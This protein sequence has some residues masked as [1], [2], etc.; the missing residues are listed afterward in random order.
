MKK[1]KDKKLLDKY[2]KENLL[3]KYLNSELINNCE[4]HIFNKNEMI[5]VLNEDMNYMYFLVK[6]KA[7]VYTFLSTGK[8]LLLCFIT[9]LSIMGDIEFL[10]NPAADCSVKALESCHCIA[11][12]ITKVK[13]FAYDDATFLRFI[14]SSLEKKLRNNANSS[15]INM[16]YPLENR[17]ASYILSLPISSTNTVEIDELTHI[18]ELL[19]SSYRHLTRVIKNL[20]DKHFIIKESNLITIL[21]MGEL[22]KLAMDIYKN[23]TLRGT[24]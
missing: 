16:L 15:S 9:P 3:Y 8:S 5:C 2:I 10:G 11:I 6:G 13:N 4:L 22:K 1:I 18:S 21:N 17:F 12:P 24:H 14:I 23:E 7:K 20:S 19:G